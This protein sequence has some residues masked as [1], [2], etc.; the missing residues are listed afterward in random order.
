[1]Y[2]T[3]TINHNP[4]KMQPFYGDLNVV[5]LLFFQPVFWGRGLLWCYSGNPAQAEL[6]CPLC[7]G[8]LSGNQYF[9]FLFY[10]V[11]PCLFQESE[12]KWQHPNLCPRAEKLGLLFTELSRAQ[13]P[14]LYV[15]LKTAASH[16]GAHPQ[17]LSERSTPGLGHVSGLC[18][19]KTV[20]GSG[21]VCMHPQLLD[22]VWALL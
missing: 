21:F 15:L 4:S 10:G 20:S 17:Q 9:E 3:Q 13:S 22:P 5:V 16:S 14:F 8:G 7:R 19:S 11:I 18:A 1:M 12:Q 2:R 6:P